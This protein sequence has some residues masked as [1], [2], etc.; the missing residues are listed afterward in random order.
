MSNL[1]SILSVRRPRW[2][3]GAGCPGAATG[4]SRRSFTCADAQPNPAANAAA[5][6]AIKAY[7]IAISIVSSSENARVHA[8]IRRRALARRPPRHTGFLRLSPSWLW[9]DRTSVGSRTRDK[10]ISSQR[11]KKILAAR[12]ESEPF[13]LRLQ[14]EKSFT[15]NAER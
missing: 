13:W 12:P 10:V 8:P 3:S 7:F 4:A 2:P 6:A 1:C 9:L 5:D 15:V 11:M 14:S